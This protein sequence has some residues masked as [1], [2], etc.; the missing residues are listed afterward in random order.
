[1]TGFWEKLPTSVIINASKIDK[2]S[3]ISMNLGKF[4]MLNGGQNNLHWRK[5]KNCLLNKN[6]QQDLNFPVKNMKSPRS[7][8]SYKSVYK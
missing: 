5:L 2:Q 8:K 7:K 3:M 4:L 6:M 1:M